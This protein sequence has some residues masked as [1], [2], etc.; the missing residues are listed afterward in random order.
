M[1]ALETAASPEKLRRIAI[2][3]LTRV[4]GHGKVTLLLDAENRVHQVRLHIVEFRGFE[5]FIEGRPYWEVP[6]TVQRLCGICPVSHHLAAVKAMDGIAGYGKLTPTAEK[7]RR[8]MHHGQILQSHAVHFFHLASPDLLLGFDSEPTRRNIVGVVA[9]YPDIAVQ[10]VMMRKYGQEVIR[11]TAGKRIHGTGAIP[12]GVNKA[13]TKAERD[14]LR[15]GIDNMIVWARDAVRLVEKLHLTHPAFYN[16]FG[17]FRSNMMGLVDS[18]GAMDLYHGGLR[19]HDA[20]GG[21]IFDHVDY[22]TYRDVLQEEV[23]PWTYMKFP[24]IKALGPE[25][26]W[27]KVGPLARVQVCDFI[28]SELAEIERK[29]LMALGQGKPVH[30]ALLYHWARMIEALHAAE[31]IRD[32]LDDPDILGTDLMADRGDRKEEG[33]GVIEA[34]RGTLFHHYCVGEDDLVKFCRLIVST[35]NNNQAMNEAIRSVASQYVNGRVIT[36]GLL[37]HIEVAI[38]AYDP[39][40]SCATHAIGQMPLQVDLVDAQGELV[41]TVRKGF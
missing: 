27:Y 22:T 24:H 40:L 29:A 16:T 30:G 3:P 15:A 14:E 23:K 10:G 4:E 7:L 28:P 6:V 8:L 34:P 39:C 33:V 38:R 21:A 36:E 11:H 31:V 1:F 32:L 9:A 25:T 12:G 17:E 20:D 35:T 2:D 41:S 13:L 37:N 19:A 26:G 18:R 5:A